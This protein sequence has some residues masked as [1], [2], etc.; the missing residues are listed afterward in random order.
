MEQRKYYKL[1]V[2]FIFWERAFEID[3]LFHRNKKY[4]KWGEL[5][6][7]LYLP[8]TKIFSTVQKVFHLEQNNFD[9]YMLFQQSLVLELAEGKIK[10]KQP[11]CICATFADTR[12][13]VRVFE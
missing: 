12:G 10:M 5:Q 6:K 9:F 4:E 13:Y 1:K 8:R 3:A 2:V 7:W 11:I